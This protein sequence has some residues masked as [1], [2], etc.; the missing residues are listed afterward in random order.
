MTAP[1]LD[2]ALR[3]IAAREDRG[4][5]LVARRVRDG[6]AVGLAVLP[7]T[8]T[9]EHGGLCAWL[10][11]LYV[12]P[13]LRARG[14]GTRLLLAAIDVVR[15]AGCRAMD[16]EVDA[17]HDR[18]ERLYLRYGFRALPRRRFTL[19][20]SGGAGTPSPRAG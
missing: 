14:I 17:E 15:D 6:A 12:I 8:W 16:L 3:G 19:R 18:V 7:F 11:E 9:V 5:V 13:E 20:F 10:D 2:S 1:D 4:R